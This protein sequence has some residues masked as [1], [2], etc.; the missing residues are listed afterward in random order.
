MIPKQA[1][2]KLVDNFLLRIEKASQIF[3]FSLEQNAIKVFLWNT[4]MVFMGRMEICY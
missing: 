2:V 1:D 4:L 3:L